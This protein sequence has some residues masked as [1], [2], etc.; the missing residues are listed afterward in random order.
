[1][2]S[3]PQVLVFPTFDENP[4]LNLL[5]L[6]PR[7]NG[8]RFLGSDTYRALIRQ[9]SRL[10]HGDVLHIHWT[11]PLLQQAPSEAAAVR[12]LRGL[13]ALFSRLRRRRVRIVWTLHNRLPHELRHRTLEI[14]LYR[15]LA[16]AADVIHVMSPATAEVVADVVAL[17]PAKV[18]MLP[19]PS[20]E[21]IYDTGIDRAAARAS[22]GLADDE[23][24]VL[25][26][27]QIR[28]YKG[29][30]ELISAAARAA[31]TGGQPIRLLLA[32]AVKEQSREEFA[33][34]IPP[35]LGAIAHL[36][37]VPDADL[38]RWFR[39]ADLAVFPYRSILNS[40]SVHLAATF[41][42]PVVLPDEPHLRRQFGSRAWVRFFD[43]EDAVGSISDLLTAPLPAVDGADWDDFLRELSPWEV[44]RGYAAMLAELS[45]WQAPRGMLSADA[46]GT[47]R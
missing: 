16:A 35:G 5:G 12:R 34:S 13:T 38:A 25:F 17:D 45:D 36:D 7:A 22:F 9:A 46:A 47:V 11:T 3:G 37:Y 23:R 30:T 21:G 28:P 32:G 4:Y 19:H 43:V 40:G 1:M 26:F 24:A 42:L 2:R 20:Y 29:V 33:A 10:G 39:A 8:F 27:G 31:D 41:T 14:R 18:R 44:S 6:A 15:A